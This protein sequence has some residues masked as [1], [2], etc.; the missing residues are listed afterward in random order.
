M[1]I[2]AA[3]AAVRTRSLSSAL[4]RAL[5][6]WG[7]FCAVLGTGAAAYLHGAS[8]AATD[9]VHAR[10]EAGVA[11]AE[12]TLLRTFEAIQGV[13]ELLQ[14]RQSL[15]E[16]GEAPGAH[17][18]QTHIKSTAAGGR[19]GI[20]QVGVTDR[21]GTGAWGT[22]EGAA[23]VSVAD[24]GYFKA[25]LRGGD[26]VFVSEPIRG[27]ST[28]RWGIQVSRPVRD[29]W[30]GL[31]GVGVV[32]L[33][34]LALSGGL[35]RDLDGAA[36]VVVVRRLGD[37]AVLA[38]SSGMEAR[39]GRPGDPDHPTVAAARL[40]PAGRIAYRATSSGRELAGAYRVP[41]G[42]PLVA[43]AVFDLTAER[44]QFRRAA[45]AVGV[46]ALAAAALALQLAL[47]WARGRQDRE[48]LQV[49]AA[50]DPLTGLLNRRALQAQA[51]R[52]L[53]E[54][55]ASGRPVSLLLLDLDHFKAI[56]DTHGHA[57]GDAVLR[58]VADV[59]A[60]EIRRG[61]L[62]CRWGG[63]E[64]LAVLKDCD[65]ASAEE[66]ALRLR[67]AIAAAA[68]GALPGLRVT[69]SI[70]VSAFPEHGP[71]LDDLTKRADKALYVAKRYGR[72]RVVCALAA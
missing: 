14:L 30:G 63:E 31:V 68:P 50:R 44:A 67:S 28:G 45:A 23:G 35:G 10:A 34:P 7:L 19:F 66:R 32:S 42:L 37:G 53:S 41:E 20:V 22:A 15:L 47:S 8:A 57:A 1:A 18:I 25:H 56:N 27:R 16:A 62:A 52:L 55:A 21:Y 60:R 9:A 4:A 29:L 26:A 3:P 6:A 40:A 33:D 46:A 12:R 54:A 58:G 24:R 2:F 11:V 5:L 59:L 13:H 51:A 71:G 61:D 69:A 39:L 17:A 36:Q 43:T 64:M 65:L 48:R 49:E 72:D 70:G 38:R